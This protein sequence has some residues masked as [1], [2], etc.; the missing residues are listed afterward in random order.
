PTD[1]PIPATNTPTPE[2][3]TD[4]PIP[5]TN[6]P[7]PEPPTDTPIPPTIPASPAATEVD[8][9]SQARNAGTLTYGDQA[10]ERV[11]EG[12][13]AVRYT[14]DGAAGD[15]VRIAMTSTDQAGLDPY[16]LLYN[17]TGDLVAE[18]D[19]G[20]DNLNSLIQTTLPADDTYTILATRF[21]QAQGTSSGQFTL[22]LERVEDTAV[23]N[24][25]TSPQP[26]AAGEAPSF[27]LFNDREIVLDGVHLL[28]GQDPPLRL[29]YPSAWEI[30]DVDAVQT[31][32]SNTNLLMETDLPIVAIVFTTLPTTEADAYF[33]PETLAQSLPGPSYTEDIVTLPDG[34]TM[35]YALS[36]DYDG[37]LLSIITAAPL[38]D[39]L[40]GLMVMQFA[41][42][43]P[44]MAGTLRDYESGILAAATAFMSGYTLAD[45]PQTN[46]PADTP[47]I[48]VRG[49][50]LPLDERFE[51]VGWN[52]AFAYPSAWRV[53]AGDQPGQAVLTN[54]QRVA[55]D[56]TRPQIGISFYAG[57]ERRP[58]L[59]PAE[60]EAFLGADYT[61]ETVSLPDGRTAEVA[62]HTDPLGNSLVGAGV[63]PFSNGDFGN[64][65]FT[66]ISNDPPIVLYEDEAFGILETLVMT[67]D[68][69]EDSTED[70]SDADAPESAYP[71]VSIADARLDNISVEV[72]SDPNTVA[73]GGGAHNRLITVLREPAALELLS[74]D[75]VRDHWQVRYNGQTAYIRTSEGEVFT[76]ADMLYI[77]TPAQHGLA[78]DSATMGLLLVPQANI[79]IRAMPETSAERIGTAQEGLPYT[80]LGFL[81]GG[82]W[83]AIFAQGR[84]GWVQ[85][86]G[87][88]AFT[89]NPSTLPVLDA[90]G[91]SV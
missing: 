91:N 72:F 34:R 28:A 66:V 40:T 89:A 13:A 59:I 60:V 46:T 33:S 57:P 12:S 17:S 20:G 87:F 49:E 42:G 29:Q 44:N 10:T 88:L 21:L 81:Q 31:L 19:D 68:S 73:A 82:G 35:R 5:A 23:A 4:T 45:A 62:Y 50:D 75:P 84:I 41:G 71:I 76:Q 14:F 3:P 85:D 43:T 2:P 52:A 79:S 56:D 47:I 65:T 63:V 9:L 22:T 1:T 16:L 11:G 32:V 83:L 55:E 86:S 37:D 67:F 53:T 51:I 25:E 54:E 48:T 78:P 64:V 30:Q 58:A 77:G 8:L 69:I 6:T 90:N 18:D 39:E 61:R 26:P 70:E 80:P 15:V 24:V 36:P 74:P 7:T 38:A 27:T